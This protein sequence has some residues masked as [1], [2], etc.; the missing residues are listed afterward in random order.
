MIRKKGLSLGFRN[1]KGNAFIEILFVIISIFIFGT[2]IIFGNRL[3]SDFNTQLQQDDQISNSSKEEFSKLN[4]RHSSVFDGLFLTI[5]VLLWVGSLVSAFVVDSHPIFFI[6]M[7]FLLIF[8]FIVI[9]ILGNTFFTIILSDSLASSSDNFPMT[10]W[11]MEHLLAIVSVMGATILI[12]MYG[13]S[14]D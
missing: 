14:R 9:G 5:L 10:L 7:I 1:K 11:V 8:A 6:V 2:V 3:S 13:G 4:N 12:S